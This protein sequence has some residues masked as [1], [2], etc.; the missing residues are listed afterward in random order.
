MALMLS[1]N[2]IKKIKALS[3]KKFRTERGQF[4]A[5]GPKLVSELLGKLH[6]SLLIATETW[7]SSNRNI[8]SEKIIS[9]TDSELKQA[10]LLQTPQD[11]LAI[12]D[13]PSSDETI[14]ISQKELVLALDD[15]QDPGNLGTIVRLADWFGIKHIFCSK[16]T[17]DIF[18][19]KAIQA[20]MGAIARVNIHYVDL[21]S[22]L[23][24]IPHNIPVYGTFLSGDDIYKTKLKNHGIIVMG[25]EGNGISSQIAG[26]VSQKLNIPSYPI[27]EAT[28]ES[29]NVAIA[30]AIICSEFRRQN[31]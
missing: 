14:L 8:K 26:C 9:V 1:K 25:N 3:V 27:G 17:A 10:S 11:V 30:T 22:E 19:P 31:R 28:S 21:S 5:E 24:D 29:L 13:I 18:N 6:C 20:T 15:V 12:F 4:I 2:E 7:L 16:G 23:S